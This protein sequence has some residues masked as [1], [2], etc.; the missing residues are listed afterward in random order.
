MLAERIRPSFLPIS[1]HVIDPATDAGARGMGRRHS[2][3]AGV[4][5]VKRCEI[6]E[7]ETGRMTDKRA[8]HN[9]AGRPLDMKDLREQ[10]LS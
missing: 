8:Q 2:A 4:F 9:E 7:G 10:H 1:P 3:Y 5:G 6:C